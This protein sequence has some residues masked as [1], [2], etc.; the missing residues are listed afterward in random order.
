[1]TVNVEISDTGLRSAIAIR[2]LTIIFTARA[3]SGI[4][5]VGIL[6][7]SNSIH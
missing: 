3:G 7:A 5:N 2:T 6:A 4:S 1:M